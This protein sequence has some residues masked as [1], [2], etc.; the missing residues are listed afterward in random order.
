MLI[1][2]ILVPLIWILRFKDYKFGFVSVISLII[3][4]NAGISVILQSVGLFKFS[5]LLGMYLLIAALTLIF[6]WK[7]LIDKI[8]DFKFGYFKKISWIFLIALT[9]IGFQLYSVHFNYTGPLTTINGIKIVENFKSGHPYFSDEWIAIGI[10]EHSIKTGELPFTNILNDKTFL[11]FLFVFHSLISGIDLLLNLNLVTAYQGVSIIFSLILITFAY[12]FLRES[13]ISVGISILIVFLISYLPNSSNLPLLWNLLPWNIGF[14]FFLAYLIAVKKEYF[15]TSIILNLLS[16]IFY[17]PLSM[18]AVP[19]FLLSLFKVEDKK[20]LIKNLTIYTGLIFVGLFISIIFISIFSSEGFVK[21][22]KTVSDFSIRDLDSALGEPPL[23]I[24][25]RVIP[26]FITPFA[27]WGLWKIRRNQAF[28]TGPVFVGLF[29]WFLYSLKFPT[30]FMD[31]HRTVAITSLLMLIVSAFCVEDFKNYLLSKIKIL[32]KEIIKK[33]L[34]CVLL[35]LFLFLSFSFT[36]RDNWMHFKTG[37]FLPTPPANNY[38]HQDDLN[39]FKNIHQKTFLAVPWKG[40]VLGMATDNKP[41]V[42][43]PSTLTINLID[44]QK[45]MVSD[46]AAKKNL[47]N[48]FNVDY[49]YTPKFECTGFELMGKSSEGLH[50]YLVK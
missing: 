26:W 36:K 37:E 39:L 14:I 27:V 24:V 22:I 43:K 40:L 5:V 30:F 21:I 32:N 47:V 20:N 44:Y 15:K 33:I 10:S 23:F 48:K 2:L 25:W 50:L 29:L 16:I 49:V 7:L 41:V 18:I 13:K 28:L 42:T 38:L 17:P 34:V 1:L 4:G 19:S 8:K 12:I 45:F 46:C 31:Y 6:N 35:A 3:A 11:N 9:T